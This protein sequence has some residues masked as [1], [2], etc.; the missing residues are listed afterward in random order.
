[1]GTA[2]SSVGRGGCATG[3]EPTEHHRVLRNLATTD[4]FAFIVTGQVLASPE[5]AIRHHLKVAC[6]PGVSVSV[7]WVPVG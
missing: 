1:V 7:T 2:L 3:F 5:Q 6:A 4:T